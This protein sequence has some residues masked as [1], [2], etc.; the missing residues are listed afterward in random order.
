VPIYTYRCSNGHDFEL[1]QSYSAEPKQP[2]PEC[3]VIASRTINAVGVVYKGSGFYTTDYARKS[4]NIPDSSSGGSKSKQAN[5]DKADT[6][7]GGESKAES[8]S[9]SSSKADSD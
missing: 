1:K 6:K 5:A 7:V 8:K 2:C 9:S 4:A 3:G